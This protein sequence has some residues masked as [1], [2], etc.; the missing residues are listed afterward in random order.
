MPN[1]AGPD[2][3][4]GSGNT[5]SL[6]NPI[7]LP[8]N[9]MRQG[10]SGPEFLACLAL[11]PRYCLHMLLAYGGLKR[12][13]KAEA[14]AVR[15]EALGLSSGL[16]APS[17]TRPLT[18]SKLHTPLGGLQRVLPR[19]SLPLPGDRSMGDQTSGTFHARVSMAQVLSGQVPIGCSA[20]HLSTQ[21]SNGSPG[22]HQVTKFLNLLHPRTV[23]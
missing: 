23:T 21:T 10:K 15:G 12:I 20:H 2:P 14:A 8:G 11:P 22:S 17:F 19:S 4:V 5:K 6:P 3:E 13:A 18:A 9:C 7:P 1:P 16:A